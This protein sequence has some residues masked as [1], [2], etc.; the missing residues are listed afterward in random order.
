[1]VFSYNQYFAEAMKTTLSPAITNSHIS[2]ENVSTPGTNNSLNPQYTNDP[3][4]TY[5]SHGSRLVTS[6]PTIGRMLYDTSSG[7]VRWYLN[8]S[9]SSSLAA[10]IPDSSLDLVKIEAKKRN[11]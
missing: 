1:M 9:F 10:F 6:D 2:K 5:E 7:S 11:R 8:T 4:P 3:Y